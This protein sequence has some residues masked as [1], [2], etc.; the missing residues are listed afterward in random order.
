MIWEIIINIVIALIIGGLA[1]TSLFLAFKNRQL[2]VK[3]MQAELD[4]M[5]VYAQAQEIFKAESSRVESKDGFVRFMSQSRD[6]AFEYIEKV[7]S[8][9]YDLKQ[10]FESS[11][12]LPRTVAQSNDLNDKIRKILENLPKEDKNV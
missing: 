4:R 3:T 7:Q 10:S 9:L 12:K 8:D 2:Y 6:W 1:I 11:Q 5:S